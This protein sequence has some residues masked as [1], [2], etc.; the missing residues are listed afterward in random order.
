MR[1][2]ILVMLFICFCLMGITACSQNKTKSLDGR[3]DVAKLI[4]N[5]F[6]T[7]MENSYFDAT[8]YGDNIMASMKQSVGDEIE[9]VMGHLSVESKNNDVIKYKFWVDSMQG[10][11]LDKIECFYVYYYPET[12]IVEI[13]ASGDISF[14][15][16]K[17]K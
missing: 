3:Y 8:K 7:D 2:R 13:I 14:K 6:T 12:D 17:S 15:F 11:I 9:Y 1:K 4:V 10:T 16:Y 5:G